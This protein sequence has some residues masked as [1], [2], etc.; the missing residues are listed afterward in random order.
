MLLKLIVQNYALIEQLSLDFNSGFTVLTGETGSGKSI[1]LGALGLVLGERADSKVLLS[2]DRKCIVEAHFDISEHGFSNYFEKYDL[3][4][5]DQTVIRREINKSGKSRAFI[6]DTPVNL[7][8]LREL[9]EQLI[10]IHSQHQTL[11]IRKRDFQ[12]NV[13]DG[14]AGTMKLKKQYQVEFDELAK[15]KN[16]L[17]D[18]ESMDAKCRA[19]ADYN[20]FQYNELSDSNLH[21]ID[22]EQLESE[23]DLLSNA[24]SL[25]ELSLEFSTGLSGEDAVLSKLADLVSVA[26]KLA[27]ISQEFAPINNRLSSAVLEIKDIAEEVELKAGHLEHD[28]E[29]I[30]MLSTQLNELNRLLF[31]HN[32]STVA[33]LLEVRAELE[34]KLSHADDLSQ[35][36]ELV[37]N[38]VDTTEKKMLELGEKLST[39]RNSVLLN[40]KNGIEKL[41]DQL[42]M[43]ESHIQFNMSR[44]VAATR[45]GLDSID[46]LVSLNKGSELKSIEKTASG[47]E[48]SRIMFALKTLLSEGSN[49]QT[50]IFDEIDTGVSGEVGNQIADLMG[51]I[52]RNKQV[53]SITHLPQ[54][55]AKGAQHFKVFKEI[56]NDI[57]QTRIVPLSRDKRLVEIAE[58]LSGKDPSEAAVQNARELLN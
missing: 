19:D 48:L 36:I 56:G 51:K 40:L 42:S 57:T 14:F 23:L 16:R 39:E 11:L 32:K 45:N 37:K 12:L 41:L 29:K 21:Q 17:K 1:I 6:N 4:Y 46:L 35:E 24:E 22:L 3:D 26:R 33:E 13:V 55:A 47:G 31:K 18:L 8:Q 52:S 49:R 53:I 58:M 25:K 27:E 54:L 9:T 15:A 43:K 20:Q 34:K 30:E 44:S 38:Q 5:E 2:E 50:I 7:S 28:P 10:D